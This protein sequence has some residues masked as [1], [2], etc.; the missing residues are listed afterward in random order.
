MPYVPIAVDNLK[1]ARLNGKSIVSAQSLEVDDHS[2]S[3]RRPEH[4]LCRAKILLKKFRFES[5]FFQGFTRKKGLF[6]LH[7]EPLCDALQYNAILNP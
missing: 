3:E 4:S 7:E 1:S 5:G 6:L 2:W